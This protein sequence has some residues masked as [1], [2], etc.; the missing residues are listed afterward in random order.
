MEI[1]EHELDNQ[2]NKLLKERSPIKRLRN[3]DFICSKCKKKRICLVPMK[4]P[5]ATCVCGNIFWEIRKH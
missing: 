1:I 5:Y 2:K 4:L 3:V